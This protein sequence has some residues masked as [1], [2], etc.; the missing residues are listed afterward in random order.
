MRM[1]PISNWFRPKHVGFGWS[2]ASWE[3]W[4]VIVLAIGLIAGLFG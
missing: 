3:G 2:P 4:A 1:N